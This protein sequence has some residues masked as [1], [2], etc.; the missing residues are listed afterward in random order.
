MTFRKTPCDM[1]DGIIISIEQ[2]TYTKDNK[3]YE[4]Y[5]ERCSTCGNLLYGYS[6]PKK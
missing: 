4:T 5:D 3:L 2:G 1:C 6:R